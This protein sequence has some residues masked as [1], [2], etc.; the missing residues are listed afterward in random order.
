MKGELAYLATDLSA[1]VPGQYIVV[2][3]GFTA[4]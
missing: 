2:D 1:Y 3:G 4:R